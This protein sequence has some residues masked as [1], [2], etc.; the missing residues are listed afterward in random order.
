MIIKSSKRFGGILSVFFLAPLFS[1]L[2]SRDISHHDDVRLWS[3]SASSFP[4]INRRFI[5]P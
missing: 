1:D 5:D 2:S 4:N 3:Q